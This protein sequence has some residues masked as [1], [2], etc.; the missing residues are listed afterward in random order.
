MGSEKSTTSMADKMKKMLKPVLGFPCVL[1][2][3]LAIAGAAISAFPGEVSVSKETGDHI[4]TVGAPS[5]LTSKLKT[6]Q[7]LFICIIISILALLLALFVK[8]QKSGD[9]SKYEI[10]EKSEKA[11]KGLDNV[12]FDG[13]KGV[14]E[15]WM[16]NYVPYGQ[17][18]KGSSIEEEVVV[19]NE[20]DSKTQEKV[21]DSNKEDE[22]WKENYVPYEDE[23]KKEEME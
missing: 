14:K 2:T 13:E 19:E 20:K 21:T 12:A 5:E 16:D 22:K 9:Q 10:N 7:D 15:K 6:A 1:V 4:A 8:L 11:S 18:P 17:F 23:E 3:I